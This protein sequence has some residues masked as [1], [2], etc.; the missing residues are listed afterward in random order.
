MSAKLSI[1]QVTMNQH[2]IGSVLDDGVGDFS[3]SVR[4]SLL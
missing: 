3:N 2:T 1:A 4:V